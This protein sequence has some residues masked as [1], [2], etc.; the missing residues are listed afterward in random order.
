[1]ANRARC[2]Q[3]FDPIFLATTRR[4]D[5]HFF[6]SSGAAAEPQVAPEY[7][8]LTLLHFFYHPVSNEHLITH[9]MHA[10]G[11]QHI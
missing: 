11:T 8:V 9:N 2:P 6:S 4:V 5:T 1:M 7:V 3:P 10:N